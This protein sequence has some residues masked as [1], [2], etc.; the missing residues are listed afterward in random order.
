M[1]VV[2]ALGA[3]IDLLSSASYVTG[4]LSIAVYHDITSKRRH[5]PSSNSLL[6]PIPTLLVSLLSPSAQRRSR[7]SQHSGCR[8][9]KRIQ[10]LCNGYSQNPPTG[11]QRDLTIGDVLDQYLVRI[12]IAGSL[13]KDRSRRENVPRYSL[14]FSENWDR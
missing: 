2:L 7:G 9:T 14:P 5:A 12:H 11:N 6:T 1:L 8:Y 13:D 3:S 10:S 4:A